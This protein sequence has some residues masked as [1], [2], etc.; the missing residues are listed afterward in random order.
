MQRPSI[1]L[2]IILEITGKCQLLCTYCTRPRAVD[3]PLKDIKKTLDEAANLGIKVIRLTGGEP[4]LHPDI[5]A[6]L[7]YAKT[8]N[9]AI[10]VNTAAENV[11]PAMMKGIITNVDAALISLQGY[12]KKSNTS[13]TR[14]KLSF[15]DK[16]KN[17]FLL[18]AYLPTLWVAT[19]ITPVMSKSF[20]KFLP[21]I[22]KINPAAWILLRPISALHKDQKKMDVPFYRDLT[23]RIM[24]ARLEH[25]NVFIANPIPLCLTG[26]LRIGQ[27]ACL[28]AKFDNGYGRI[29]RSADG[30][31]KPSYFLDTNLGTTI[32][33]AWKH[34]FLQELNRT[35]YLP[36]LCQRCPVLD[37]CRGGCRSMAL[38]AYQTALGP[39]PLFRPAIAQKA[40]S[41][42]HLMSSVS[43]PTIL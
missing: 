16:I 39:D 42:P 31:F 23:L 1:P 30:F 21:L 10:I 9:L 14:S 3:V 13:Y 5:Q 43:F 11:S 33:T 41:K 35:D 19:V 17:I 8:K 15:L 25:I 6:I 12:D 32:K 26:D 18:K 27:Q 28:G 20:E 38:R 40:L 22:K 29:V 4:L 7:T 37:T 24:K 36:R 34:P 2:E